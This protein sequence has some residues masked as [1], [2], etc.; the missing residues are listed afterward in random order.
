MQGGYNRAVERFLPSTRDFR[1]WDDLLWI[2]GAIGVIAIAVLLT[3]SEAGY[4]THQKLFLPPCFFRLV[5]HLNCPL[6]G[7]TTSF[8]HMARGNIVP[9]VSANILGPAAA[10]L[11]LAQ[12]PFRL[13]RLLGRPVPTPGWW[14]QPWLLW[15]ASALIIVCW[16]VN[17][18]LQFFGQ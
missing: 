1:K 16:P 5:T 6:C 14:H 9:A 11:L 7:L 13:A 4:G 17:I 2:G 8:C 10:L 18:Y 3:P 12:I 15:A